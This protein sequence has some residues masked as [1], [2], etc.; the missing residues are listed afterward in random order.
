MSNLGLISFDI[1]DT[2]ITR[3]VVN[4]TM[5]FAIMQ[6]ALQQMSFN[7]PNCLVKNFYYVRVK[8]EKFVRENLRINENKSEI[9]LCDIYD[10][11]Q[12]NFDLTE[13]QKD[14]HLNLEMQI[15][16]K[17]I[18]PIIE[19]INKLKEFV[20]QGYKVI[21]ISDMYLP[22]EAIR[23]ILIKFDQIFEKL[24]IYV[25]SEY[26]K[27]KSN[28]SMY[29][30]L[31]KIYTP[32]H[33]I[34][35]G[36]NYIADFFI[37]ISM[38]IKAC[39]YRKNRLTSYEKY[40]LK[41]QKQNLNIDL[42]VGCAKNLRLKEENE[43]YIFG[44][45]FAAPI[46]YIYVKWVLS[47]CRSKKIRHLY[48]VARDGFLLK[49]IADKLNFN[50]E[51]IT[52]YFCTS[53]K[54][55]SSIKKE[56]REMLLSLYIDQELPQSENCVAFIDINGSGKTQ[57]YITECLNKLRACTTYNFYLHNT[58][59]VKQNAK[60]IKCSMIPLTDSE[61]WVEYLC[62]CPEGQTI[63][64]YYNEN[65][66]IVP[67]KE[68]NCADSMEKWGFEDYKNGI[69]DYV[70]EIVKVESNN[71]IDISDFLL[72]DL[73]NQY[74]H[75]HLDKKTAD[76]IG[77]IPFAS[78][79][80]EH[81]T[82]VAEQI[83]LVNLFCPKYTDYISIA[84]CNKLIKPIVYLIKTIINPRTYAYINKDKNLAYLK[85]YKYKLDIRKLIW[86]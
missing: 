42:L 52:H 68:K 77:S 78:L 7:L 46:L 39:Y 85:I 49:Q 73:M 66:I 65:N 60:S 62:R 84:R 27:K 19:N 2:L 53:R 71:N 35:F 4:P 64:Y 44:A 70:D 69:F 38:G 18:V 54:A 83:N 56:N 55:C 58:T 29:N 43:K 12:L 6:N 24:E 47:Q 1:F 13:K 21:L 67:L 28:K 10:Y 45:S 16:G 86:R 41:E 37:P 26:N 57:D 48:F 34:H 20:L 32:T 15:E 11:I 79:G 22:S 50:N 3:T 63:G 40:I 81:N 14:N 72:F 61:D 30:Y 9:S 23:N 80:E 76:I 74:I 25:S 82:V 31:K 5:I 51:F 8:S 17:N 75:N 59:T 36:D 33:W